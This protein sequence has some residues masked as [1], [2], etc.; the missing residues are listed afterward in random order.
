MRV[1]PATRRVSSVISTGA[2]SSVM[3]ASNGL[4][5]SIAAAMATPP[6]ISSAIPTSSYTCVTSL[7]SR[8]MNL[9]VS[10]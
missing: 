9:P 3:I 6:T 8:V 2:V 7:T 5:Q 10:S 4:S 1:R